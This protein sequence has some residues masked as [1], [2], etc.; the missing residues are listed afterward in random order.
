MTESSPANPAASANQAQ[1]PLS[2]EQQLHD[3]F[4]ALV[5]GAIAHYAGLQPY[6]SESWNNPE[7]EGRTI[8][9]G[10]FH[11]GTER[12]V[13]TEKHEG[14]KVTVATKVYLPEAATDPTGR[15]ILL[16]TTPAS[17]GGLTYDF[18]CLPTSNQSATIYRWSAHQPVGI[19]EKVKG[20]DRSVPVAGDVSDPSSELARAMNIAENVGEKWRQLV[21]APEQQNTAGPKRRSLGALASAAL[22]HIGRR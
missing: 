21:T 3:S 13:I 9:R 11:D 17:E 20:V 1:Q 14:A 10:Y 19:V 2:P 8:T 16:M 5:D 22:R 15:R 18:R 6:K 4:T 12:D 7:A